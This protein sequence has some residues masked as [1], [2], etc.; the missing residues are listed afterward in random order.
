HLWG[1]S[2][3]ETEKIIKRAFKGK[4]VQ[5]ASIGV[6]GE[7]MVRTACVVHGHN[8]AG[9]TGMGAV[10]G[11]K[12]LKAIAIRYSKNRPQVADPKKLN[13][14]ARQLR[15]KIKESPFYPMFATYGMAGPLAV[16]NESGILGVRNLQQAGGFEDVEKV[17]CETLAKKFY[18]GSRSCFSCSIGCMKEWEVKEGPY[19]GEKGTKIPEGCNAPNGPNC[20]NA[21][22]PSLFKIYNLCN[23]WGIDV[24]DFGCLMSYIMEW[25]ERGIITPE[26]TDGLRFD[27]GNYETMIAMIPKIAMREG[28]GGVVADGAVRAAQRIGRGA[29]K[30]INSCKGMVI[31]GQD[32]R[33][34]KGTALCF[35][36][37]T[38]GCDHLRGSNMLEVQIGGKSLISPEDAERR[39]GTTQVMEHDSYEKA[40]PV[41]YFQDIYTLADALQICKFITSHNGHGINIQDMAGL[42]SAATGLEADEESMRTCAHR[43][44]TLERCFLVRE[45]ITGEDDFLQGKWTNEATRGGPF[46]GSYFDQEKFGKMLEDYYRQRGWNTVTGLPTKE[47][48]EEL[49]LH[50]AA[51]DL[52][53]MGKL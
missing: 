39:F 16:E 30:Y 49:G 40:R 15:K 3:H 1:K 44:Y 28:F 42:Y 9:R 29:E 12:N 53:K 7:K 13:A 4:Q 10:M 5:I 20:G 41:I 14:V 21:Y 45:G 22:A 27:W 6:A 11:S 48:L 19:A 35:A 34:L 17:T 50:E 8:V 43:I 2:T 25:Y 24:L 26:E 37:A 52:Q 36:T 32:I 31:G 47:T 23:Q 51:A 38:R 46:D 33:G 18:T